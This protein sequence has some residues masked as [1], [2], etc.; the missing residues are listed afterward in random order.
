MKTKIAL[1][2][3]SIRLCGYGAPIVDMFPDCEVVQPDDN[4]RFAQYTFRMLFDW[5]DTIKGSKVIHWNNGLWDVCDLFG[6]G[7]FSTLDEYVQNMVRIARQLKKIT[8]NV[9]F[10]TTTPVRDDN[11][12]N[13]NE[14]IKAFN[15]AVVLA[16]KKEGII[17]NDLF[18][19]VYDKRN[20]YISAEDR[21]HLTKE[22][23]AVCAKQVA[24]YIQEA[25]D[26]DKGEGQVCDQQD[27][28]KKY[29]PI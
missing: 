10:A 2:G 1:L 3:D 20:E 12:Y 8:P 16:L 6:D 27:F 17:I 7:T 21:I 23:A 25:L 15:E 5:A 24:A 22:G 14:D 18:G 19:L 26:S 11:P 29:M 28:L 13:S 9:I 4:C